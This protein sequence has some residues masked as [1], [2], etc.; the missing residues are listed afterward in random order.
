MIRWYRRKFGWVPRPVR[1]VI[2]SV[3]GATLLLLAVAGMILPIMPG[4]I[5]LPIALAILS[6]EFAF[7]A[8][9]LKRLKRTA[10]SV[11]QRVRDTIAQSGGSGTQAAPRDPAPPPPAAPDQTQD[12]TQDRAQDHDQNSSKQSID[13][14]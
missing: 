2:V 12:Q 8:R 10:T 9:W 11:H 5:F 1:Q 3:I 14:R 13:A 6:L 4:L 7:A